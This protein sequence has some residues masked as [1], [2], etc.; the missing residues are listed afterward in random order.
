MTRGIVAVC[1]TTLVTAAALA[2]V[3]VK[4]LALPT[5]GSGVAESIAGGGDE[6]RFAIALHLFA[7]SVHETARTD[8]AFVRRARAEAALA[9][10]RGNPHV[11]SVAETLL[12]VLALRDAAAQPKRAAAFTGT[13]FSAFRTAL[14]LDP[15][16]EQAAADLEQLFARRAGK[17]HGQPGGPRKRGAHK[18]HGWEHGRGAGASATHGGGY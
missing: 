15:D 1:A 8:A 10:Q 6:R 12:G 9:A 14:R 13:A 2:F 7:D 17:Q 5:H 16:N 4:L 11:R 18:A 3:G